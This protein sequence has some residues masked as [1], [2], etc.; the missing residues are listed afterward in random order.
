MW[1]DQELD[2]SSMVKSLQGIC[3]EAR[4]LTGRICSNQIF[5]L[6]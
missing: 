1:D 2:V 6:M 4:P 5:P 3:N